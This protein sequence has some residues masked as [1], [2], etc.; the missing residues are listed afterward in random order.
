MQSSRIYVGGE[1]F[2]E[3]PAKPSEWLFSIK[4]WDSVNNQC[5]TFFDQYEEDYV[6]ERIGAEVVKKLDNICQSLAAGPGDDV[7]FSRGWSAGCELLE[8]ISKVD[9][10]NSIIE[11][12][13]GLS[14]AMM[15]GK[16]ISLSL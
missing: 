16:D 7:V 3:L 12:K 11:F 10:L 5:D 13:N 15:A 6:D 1:L 4:F 14:A 8:S 9:L 2:F